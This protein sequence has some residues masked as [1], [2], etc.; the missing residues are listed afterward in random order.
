MRS[1][2]LR[3]LMYAVPTLLLISFIAFVVIELPP[4]DYMTTI[5]QNLMAQA[6]LSVS[7]A[8]E[9]ADQ[10]RRV[11]GLD[12]PFLVRYF[13]W[14]SGI[15]TRGDFGF[16][17]IYR[18]P[19]SEVIWGRLGM[20][21]LVALS[22]HLISVVVGVLI[23]IYSATHRNSF[24]DAAA[25]VF[26]FIGLSMPN[27]FLALVIMYVLSF[28]FGMHV[29]GFFSPQYVIAPWSLERLIDFLQ[30]FW[31]PVLVVGLA[32]TARNMRV[33]RSNLLDVL[34]QQYV[35]TARAKGLEER[36]VIYRHAVRNAIQP[37][38]MYLGIALPFLLQGEIVTSAVMNLPTMGP[39]FLAAL[40]TQDMYLAGSFLLLLATVLVIGNLLADI[41]LAWVD[42]RVRYD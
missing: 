37:L 34:H 21:L 23:G 14:V 32:G 31:V 7:E 9:I 13:N 24:F 35:Q 40:T 41:A 36:V 20:T 6:G 25:T 8:R 26:A 19:V 1:Y 39:V 42:P 30:H 27:F 17:F 12:K 38:V 5:Q 33:M 3:R 11:Y 22:S 10:M 16:S 18:R 15:I 28:K 29:G 2:I 4:G